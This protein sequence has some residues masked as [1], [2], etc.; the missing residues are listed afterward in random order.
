MALRTPLSVRGENYAPRAALSCMYSEYGEYV[1]TGSTY[2]E[3]KVLGVVPAS[4][5]DVGHVRC[6][7]PLVQA[8]TEFEQASVRVTTDGA[9][10]SESSA[11]FTYFTS[12]EIT[13]VT[14]SAITLPLTPNPNP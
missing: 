6:D 8:G 2:S 5:V 1:R 12:P 9:T 14:P 7:S 4:F 11:E 3:F 10:Y 13:E